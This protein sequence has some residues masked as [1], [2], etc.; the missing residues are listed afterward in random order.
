M[1]NRSRIELIPIYKK[2]TTKLKKNNIPEEQGE[3]FKQSFL[4]A[5]TKASEDVTC[6]ECDADSPQESANFEATH[7]RDTTESSYNNN[8]RT[9]SRRRRD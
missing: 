9:G 3:D 1:R 6:D 2:W 5:V 7:P 4:Y 8:V